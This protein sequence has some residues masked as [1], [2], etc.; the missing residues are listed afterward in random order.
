MGDCLLSGKPSRYVT[1]HLGHSVTF[2]PTQVITPRLIPS[3]ACRYSIYLP[4]R[5]GR[6]GW[7]S[8][9]DS[10][11]ARSR[12]S[13]LSIT[14]PTLNHCTTKTTMLSRAKNVLTSVACLLLDVLCS[15]W[16]VCRACK[17]DSV[18][19]FSTQLVFVVVVVVVDVDDVVVSWLAQSS[20][21]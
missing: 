14:S 16:D 20:R 6:L 11:P 1:N 17:S 12:T 21:G 4:R 8:W 13:D 3:R 9:L 10:A 5:D 15:C 2:H 19:V 7:P 18:T